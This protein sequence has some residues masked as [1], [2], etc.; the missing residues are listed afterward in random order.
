[1]FDRNRSSTLKR[2]MAEQ[3]EDMDG[4]MSALEGP[5]GSAIVSE[6]NK[7]ALKKLSDQLA[8]GKK[9]IAIFYGAAHM[10]DIEKRL[11]SEF[12]LKRSGE[13]WLTAW[14]LAPPAPA[15]PARKPAA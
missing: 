14:K 1:L 10:N 5:N 3:F 12:G 7:V 2:I 15:K 8:A 13:E 11:V 6:R 9:K 4:A